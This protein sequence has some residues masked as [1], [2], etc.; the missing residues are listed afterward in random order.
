[1]T[2]S[3]RLRGTLLAYGLFDLVEFSIWMAVLLYAYSKGGASLAGLVSIAQLVP[4][5]LLVPFLAGVGDRIPRGR[6]LSGAHVGVAVTTG[7]TGSIL[8]LSAPVPVVVLGAAAATTAVALVRP[9]HFAALPQLA[10][11]PR[12]LVSANSV[13]SGLDA[14]GLFVGPVVAGILSQLVGPWLVFVAASLAA[15]TAAILTRGLQLPAGALDDVGQRP[16]ALREAGAG[17]RALW[18]DWGALALLLVMGAKFVVEGALDVL[19]VSFADSVL[20]A[21]GTSAGLMIGSV[22]IGAL[23]GAAV[24]ATLAVRA[25]LTPVIVAGGSVLGIGVASVS[26]LAGLPPVMIVMALAGAGAA[27]LMVAGRTLLQR[28][29]DDRVMARVFAV[30]ESVGLLGLAIGAGLAPLLISR[31]SVAGA[32]VPLGLGVVLITIGASGLMR[33]LDRRA[34]F[35]ADEVTLLRSIDVLALLPEYELERLAE[36]AR[37]LDFAPGDVVLRRG[38]PCKAV[39]IVATG[40]FTVSIN[41]IEQHERLRIGRTFGEL[42]LP[43]CS[44]RISSVTAK[45]D[46]RLLVLGATEFVVGEPSAGGPDP[47]TCALCLD[48]S[49]PPAATRTA[50]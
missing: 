29:T 43:S 49:G 27:L 13:S 18:G 6:A 4:A 5:L 31:F 15:G 24:S 20:L 1:M 35:R 42:A 12:E 48:G 21:G 28:S 46:G 17:L 36:H 7:L 16:S 33:R 40:E 25:R 32:F 34:T 14:A 2:L 39:Y 41:G 38:E 30:Q 3:P 9:I 26:M 37:W 8:L 47:T 22:G 11:T 45:T 44:T 50:G 19:G 23:I 10:T